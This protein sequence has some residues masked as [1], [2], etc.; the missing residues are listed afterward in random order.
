MASPTV[1]RTL[2][3]AVIALAFAGGLLATDS[4]QTARLIASDGGA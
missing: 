1:A 2:L 4:A 3:I